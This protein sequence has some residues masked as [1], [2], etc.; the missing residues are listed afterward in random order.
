MPAIAPNPADAA[1]AQQADGRDRSAPIPITA[2]RQP[3]GAARKWVASLAIWLL[4]VPHYTILWLLGPRLG[5]AW[6]RLAANIHWLASF[7]G[8]QRS[9]R[10]SLEKL[11]PLL[12]TDLSV[13]ALLR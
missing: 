8:A 3:F 10:R 11:H 1:V 4:Y 2:A 13:S 5:L 6:V 9:T 7:L 12:N